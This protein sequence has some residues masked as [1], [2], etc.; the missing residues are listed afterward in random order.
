M[1]LILR[2]RAFSRH[3]SDDH[4]MVVTVALRACVFGGQDSRVFLY[5]AATVEMKSISVSLLHVYYSD[6]SRMDSYMSLQT[7]PAKL[8][9][10]TDTI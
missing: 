9:F 3:L 8:L 6:V 5:L 10:T 4:D 1:V 7:R 2:R